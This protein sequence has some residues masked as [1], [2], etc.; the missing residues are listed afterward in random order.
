M[1]RHWHDH[2]LSLVSFCLTNSHWAV[3]IF[4]QSLVI[5]PHTSLPHLPAKPWPQ[6]FS[7]FTSSLCHIC[8]ALRYL[9]RILLLL[10]FLGYSEA[11]SSLC[12]YLTIQTFLPGGPSASL[13]S[14]WEREA[15]STC[16]VCSPA[17]PNCWKLWLCSS[18][19]GTQPKEAG[20]R[21]PTKTQAVFDFPLTSSPSVWRLLSQNRQFLL[22]SKAN[23]ALGVPAPALFSHPPPLPELGFWN[24]TA[25]NWLLQFSLSP[26]SSGKEWHS[27]SRRTEEE[28]G[29]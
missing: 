4:I 16:F 11:F 22:S 20:R 21:P 3:F 28:R 7:R 19:T 25:K 12:T 26:F 2:T 14:I 15:G 23:Q 29:C 27:C 8:V 18:T 9:R 6:D 10:Y 13:D 17:P 1:R 5:C 24:S